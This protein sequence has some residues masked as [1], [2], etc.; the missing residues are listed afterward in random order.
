MTVEFKNK[1]TDDIFLIDNYDQIISAIKTDSNQI[2]SKLLRN[3]EKMI[4]E[5]ELSEL[6]SN[7]N[8]YEQVIEVLRDFQELWLLLNG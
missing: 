6:L 4:I 8:L 5:N 2:R 1:G 3:K 7:I